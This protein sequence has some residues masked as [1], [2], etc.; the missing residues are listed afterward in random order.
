MPLSCLTY[1]GKTCI[2]PPGVLFIDYGIFL[3]KEN[4]NSKSSKSQPRLEIFSQHPSI[5]RHFVPIRPQTWKVHTRLSQCPPRLNFSLSDL[6]VAK[7]CTLTVTMQ[8]TLI[9]PPGKG[10]HK[11]TSSPTLRQPIHTIIQITTPNFPK[12][13]ED[14]EESH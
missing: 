2:P 10:C 5:S 9:L 7:T 13:S 3:A 1:D 8:K 6:Q 12:K 11:L 14:M 4:T